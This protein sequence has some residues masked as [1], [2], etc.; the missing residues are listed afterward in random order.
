MSAAP[1]PNWRQLA[2]AA[3]NESDHAKLLQ[4]VGQLCN[5]LD[6]ASSP[7]LTRTTENE[8]HE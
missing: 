5:A 1:V 3:S 8:G 4:I 7:L 2:E 6:K